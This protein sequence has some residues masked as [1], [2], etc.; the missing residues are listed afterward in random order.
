MSFQLLTRFNC[1]DARYTSPLL[2]SL[3]ATTSRLVRNTRF[4]AVWSLSTPTATSSVSPGQ[5][6]T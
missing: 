4:F 3:I 6:R 5:S 2:V 1:S